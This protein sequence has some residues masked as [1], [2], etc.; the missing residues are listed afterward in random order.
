VIPLAQQNRQSDPQTLSG[1]FTNYLAFKKT[2]LG[3]LITELETDKSAE[4]TSALLKEFIQLDGQARLADLATS[5]P[6][7]AV[8]RQ[9]L[10]HMPQESDVDMP[11]LT[12]LLL[13][14]IQGIEHCA[15]ES[16]QAETSRSNERPFLALLSLAEDLITQYQDQPDFDMSESEFTLNPGVTIRFVTECRGL[17]SRMSSALSGLAGKT[18]ASPALTN[19]IS[20]SRNLLG[21]TELL[22]GACANSPPFEHPASTLLEGL[23]DL[24]DCLFEFTQLHDADLALIREPLVQIHSALNLLLD[25]IQGNRITLRGRVEL[26]AALEL[27]R[28]QLN[29]IRS[30]SEDDDPE[31]ELV[32][33]K[34]PTTEQTAVQYVQVRQDRIEHLSRLASELIVSRS[35]ISLIRAMIEQQR[36]FSE[37]INA[38]DHA[39]RTFGQALAELERSVIEIRMRR[40]GE[41]FDRFPR[42]VRDL[43]K[44]QNKS[45]RVKLSGEETE[46]DNTILLA[47]ADPLLH[48]VNNACDHGIESE[49]E[50]E[51]A[52]KPPA[53]TLNLSAYLTGKEVVIE[54]RDDGRGIDPAHIRDKA[55]ERGLIDETTGATLCDDEL[56]ELIF[57]PAFSTA[58]EVTAV[59]GRGVGMDVVKHNLS[60]VNGRVTLESRTGEYSCFKLYLPITMSISRGLVV[61]SA[62]TRYFIPLEQVVTMLGLDH[63]A[64]HAHLNQQLMRLPDGTVP[65]QDLSELLGNTRASE[66]GERHTE[67][68]VLKIDQTRIAVGVDQILGIEDMAI[69]PLP[70]RMEHLDVYLGCSILADGCV[71]PVL[72]PRKLLGSQTPL[73][74]GTGR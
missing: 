64:L 7:L 35:S 44:E 33:Q 73:T 4:T 3:L 42:R 66:P 43:A 74:I 24:C 5:L 54:V 49:V 41:L 37:L 62:T 6:L 10:I 61:L 65:Y 47:V 59:S 69:R 29:A 72:N 18:T 27:L 51:K 11:L 16:Q 28:G 71:V 32:G 34:T 31:Y 26:G 67:V 36:P 48:L 68:V 55:I 17:L 25:D 50:R 23:F 15:Y 1:V 38:L 45:I 58:R 46:L 14:L 70:G 22:L 56:R 8:C 19:V 20:T 52:G 9:L 21:T 57:T 40:I 63:A 13:E 2:Y 30:L 53:A 12:S 60:K 39:E